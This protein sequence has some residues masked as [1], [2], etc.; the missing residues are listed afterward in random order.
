MNGKAE[1]DEPIAGHPELL[2]K[3][4]KRS[5]RHCLRRMARVVNKRKYKPRLD[6]TGSQGLMRAERRCAGPIGLST[7]DKAMSK[8]PQFLY[9]ER[10]ET[11]VFIQ[12][13]N[14][15]VAPGPSLVRVQNSPARSVF[16][17]G[18]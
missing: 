4:S 9:S 11:D 18:C 10:S 16:D 17:R 5:K 15:T 14:V 7:V 13:I 3:E 2:K 1:R 6:L 12:G 8:N